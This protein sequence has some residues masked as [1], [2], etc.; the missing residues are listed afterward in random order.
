MQETR[1]DAEVPR[2]LFDLKTHFKKD[3]QATK[4]V[5]SP[6]PFEAKTGIDGRPELFLDLGKLIK[7][8]EKL[9]GK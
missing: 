9:T 6:I 3:S 7:L 4:D 5:G 2:W 8:V 1:Y